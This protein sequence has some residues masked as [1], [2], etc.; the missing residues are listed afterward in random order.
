MSRKRTTTA[1]A[2]A[3]SVLNRFETQA[4]YAADILNS[5]ISELPER[6]Q[7]QRATDLVF[8]SIRNRSAIDAVITKLADCPIERI[9]PKIVNILRS[10]CYE[11]IYC[12]GT[13]EYSIVNEAVET[14][15][16]AAGKK[17]AG[18]VNAVLRK[19]TR[20]ITNRQTGLSKAEPQKIIPL[21]P[22]I[23]CEFD[24][25][26]LPDIKSSPADFFSIA[27]SLPVWL[28]EKWLE[29]FGTESTRQ[30]CF[31]SNRRP[32]I[33][34]RA[35]TLK[36]TALKIAENL[37][38]AGIEC[39]VTDNKSMLRV[40]SGS[41]V[42]ELPGFERGDFTVQD[43][44]AAQAVRL[45]NPQPGS[46]ILDSC[47]APGTKTTQLAEVTFDKAKIFAAD[48]DRQRLQKAEENISRLGVKSVTIVHYEDIEKIVEEEKFDCV[49]LDVPCSNTGV[50]SK[51]PE[52]RFR[53]TQKAVKKLT[54]TQMQLLTR[55]AGMIKTGGKICYST[56]SIQ[57]QENNL[58]L[59]KFLSNNADFT[60]E[61]EKLTL[62]AA[63]DFDRDGGYVAV[64]KHL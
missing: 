50:L 43:I 55:A 25:V 40:K 26:V 44:T 23:G 35:N 10:A 8:G 52:A 15:K 19:I 30:I 20:H 54:E 12:P 59:G 9:E 57:P 29:E 34:I 28:V 7:R 38:Q 37:L 2:L 32:S 24:L 47:A 42:T 33:Y 63:G 61:T 14:A 5:R 49:L 27:F 17:Q 21:N 62:P 16:A 18:F 22:S 60:V 56:C 46:R 64:I 39:E 3:V 4:N 41:A 51:R 31:S 13:P 6:A 36:T 58:L 45:L 53:I 1:R 11:L 48:I